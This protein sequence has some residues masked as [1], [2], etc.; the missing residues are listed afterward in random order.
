MRSPSL[1]LV[2]ILGTRRRHELSIVTR[3]I[4]DQRHRAAEES[5]GDDLPT[6]AD[7]GH[8]CPVLVDELRDAVERF[9]E[10]DFW[11]ARTLAGDSHPL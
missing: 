4:A 11:P 6:P 7:P 9:E 2:A 8:R 1:E 5:R 10:V 3:V